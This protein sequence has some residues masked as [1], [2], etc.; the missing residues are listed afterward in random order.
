MINI[1]I[2]QMLHGHDIVFF[3]CEMSEDMVSQRV[4]SIIT[5]LD[6]NRIYDMKKSEFLKRLTI[7][8]KK[9]EQYGNL[10]IKEYPTGTANVNDFKAY[11]QELKMRGIKPECI[12]AD[13]LSIMQPTIKISSENTYGSGK[14]IAE[15]LRALS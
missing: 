7:E 12:F 9:K 10:Y 4:D 11:L 1:A 14:K 3:T 13:Y 6:I 8:G 15:E 2:R 5:K